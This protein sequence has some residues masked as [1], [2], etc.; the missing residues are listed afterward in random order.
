MR[1]FLALPLP[2]D[3]R[4]AAAQACRAPGV[5]AGD[6]RWVREEGLHVTIRFLG[7]VDPSRGGMLDAAWREA[8]SG[9]GPIDLRVAGLE[10]LPSS[11]RPR[12]VGL[13]I[14]DATPDGRLARL[15]A[16]V[17]D[18]ARARGFAPEHRAFNPHVTLA[19]ARRGVRVVWPRAVSGDALG[20]FVAESLV[21]YA[22]KLGPGGSRYRE[23]ASYPLAG[24]VS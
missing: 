20:A 3:L 19:R 7:E 13:R 14:V 8:A 11:S 17:E 12:V 16:R 22:S 23:L 18:A 24:S 15:A 21:L 6:W 2:D 4:R 5:P 10:A 9:V 1:E